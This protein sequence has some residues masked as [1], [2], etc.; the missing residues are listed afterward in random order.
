MIHA[1]KYRL[2]LDVGIQLL[3]F[4]LLI[5]QIII[6]PNANG[7][8]YY[9]S[10]FGMILSLWQIIHAVYVV[11]KYQDWH[12]K[13]YL[14]NMKQVLA[15]GLMTLFVG[16]FMILT[17]FGFLTPFFLFTVHILHWVVCA[18]VLFLALKYFKIS[19]QRLYQYF[20]GP[21]SFWDLK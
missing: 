18:V 17:S 14:S 16:F 19:F 8:L 11:R 9:A 12:R 15:Y 6:H 21:K 10:I 7:I 5:I 20:Y 4:I 13:Q 2:I 3:L 1:T